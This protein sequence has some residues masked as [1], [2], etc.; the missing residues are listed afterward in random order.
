MPDHLA[1]IRRSAF[2]SFRPYLSLTGSKWSFATGSRERPRPRAPSPSHHEPSRPRG[3]VGDEDDD[4]PDIGPS[5]S[6]PRASR[7]GPTLPTAADRQ[8]AKEEDREE[9]RRERKAESRNKYEKANEAVPRAGGREGKIEEKRATNAQNK[10]MRE[11]DPTGGLELD[12]GTLLGSNDSFAAASVVSFIFTFS[13]TRRLR[14]RDAAQSWRAEK[15]AMADA[16]R[17]AADEEW[18]AERKAKENATM[19]MFRALARQRFG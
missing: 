13:L 9:R 16:D 15:K 7:V 2:L 17:R 19:D 14:A 4:E 12:E 6:P 3:D 8:L 11:K 5:L 10:E 18:L 1:R